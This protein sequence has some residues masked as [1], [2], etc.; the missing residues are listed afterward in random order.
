[1]KRVV[2]SGYYGFG[3]AGDDAIAA[4]IVRD[5]R[6]AVPD[7]APVILSAD[8]AATARQ[9]GV[10]AVHRF[11]T[12]GITRALARADLLVSGG[13]TL[14]QDVTSTRS[15]LY[16]LG[17]LR[18][19][20]ALG[21]P[22]MLYANGIGPIRRPWNRRV[23]RWVVDRVQVISV[24]DAESRAALD[25]LGIRG[26]R[27][28]VTAD[29][30][31]SLRPA[32]SGRARA[33]LAAE[34]V[35]SGRSLVGVSV[36]PWRGASPETLAALADGLV[37]RFGL[38]VLF[39]PMQPSRDLPLALE[40]RNRM[41][42]PGAVLRGRYPADE[43]L[44]VLGELRLLLGMRLHSLIFA[45]AQGV[46]V[47]GLAYDPKVD[48]FL[49]RVRQLCLGPVEDLDPAAALD[50]VA[51]VLATLEERRQALRERLPALREAA[52]RNAALAAELLA[53]RPAPRPAPGLQR[54][55]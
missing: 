39:V 43:L 52:R 46:P 12:A 20:R 44:A 54:G 1:M 33:I 10:E 5:L 11:S 24:R 23:T 51:A 32:D 2:I 42:E 50:A 9:L 47:V 22:A 27:V 18:L 28:E 25:E 17:V 16:Y 4:A 8:P 31:F 37:S 48:A 55:G 38:G 14:L 53:G 6:D 49:A 13:G 15:L 7:V 41:R 35:P 40:V 45:V 29:P 19:A 30:V 34:G 21:V 36:R 3:N 26:P